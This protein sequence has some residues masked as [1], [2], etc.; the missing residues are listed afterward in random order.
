MIT[1]DVQQ[2]NATPRPR[3]IPLA[4]P[5]YRFAPDLPSR[6]PSLD[7]LRALSI[8]LVIVS[9]LNGTRGFV[10]YSFLEDFGNFGVRVFFVISGFLIT[11]LLLKEHAATGR[12]SIAQFYLR[13]TFRIFPAFYAF[14]LV[15]SLLNWSRLITLYPND[16]IHAFTYTMN[17]HHPHSWYLGHIWSLSVEEQFYF[18]WPAILLLVGRRRGLIYAGSVILLAPWIRFGMWLWMPADLHQGVDQQFQCIADA[19][20]FGCLLAGLHNWLSE[21]DSYLRFLSSR[22]FYAVPVTAFLVNSMQGRPRVWAL[23]GQTVT[24]LAIALF[25]DRYVR[26]SGG[27]FGRLLNA[28]PLRFIGVLSYSLY[29]W[30]QVFLNR[31]S[32]AWISSFPV[33]LLLAAIAALGSYFVVE[34]PF[35]RLK[36]HLRGSAHVN[37][38]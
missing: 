4:S 8:A 21:R 5:A 18:L 28:R 12:I 33:N 10:N 30:Q 9:H 37:T 17:F 6:I 38:A 29:L 2:P 22:W 16:L 25:L 15:I 3:K 11:T 27:P 7:G 34:R 20:A 13:R 23:V 35:L 24:T 31:N 1:G 36:D 32:E 26:F 14:V 19:L